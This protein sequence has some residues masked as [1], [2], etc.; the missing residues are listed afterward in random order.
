MTLKADIKYKTNWQQA[1]ATG[2]SHASPW[3]LVRAGI[4]LLSDPPKQMDLQAQRDIA[5]SRD[6][7]AGWKPDSIASGPAE[8]Y[9]SALG[10]GPSGGSEA[11]GPC[12]ASVTRAHASQRLEPDRPARH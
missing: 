5:D 3:S 12:A 6:L 8:D 10:T 11:P 9:P 4:V 2:T 1:G 7:G